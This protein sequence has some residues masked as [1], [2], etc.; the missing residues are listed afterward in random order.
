MAGEFADPGG[1]RSLDAVTGR[2]TV[3]S[4]T[5]YL[6]LLTAAPSDAQTVGTISVTEYGATGYARQSVTW[7]S[8]T[9]VSNVP[10]TSNSDALTFGPFTAGTGAQITH[11]A[12][13]S[14][15][16]GTSGDL[17]AWW[18]LTTPRTPAANDSITVAAG[19]ITLSVD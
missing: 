12:L 8:P 7:A 13:V 18:E 15:A 4:R 14:A 6:A 1:Y 2:A 17:V 19:A 9:L 5:T 11:A 16:S 3:S 10:Q